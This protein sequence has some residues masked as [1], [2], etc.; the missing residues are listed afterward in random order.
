MAGSNGGTFT[1]QPDGTVTF[2]PGDDFN[3]LGVG[4]TATTEITYTIDDGQGGTD[5]ATIVQTVTGV[6]DAPI[7]VDP[8]QPPID[9][10]NPPD[11]VPFDPQ[12]PF[13]PPL[14]PENYIPVQSGDD[15][16]PQP[17]LDLTPYFGDPD[18]PDPV[19]LSIDPNDLPP[20]LVFDPVTG[21]ISGTP[22]LDASQGGDPQNPGTYVIPVTAIDPS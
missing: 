3:G 7:P 10:N 13:N 18:S 20:G 17:P 8:T 14:D 9:P 22:T 19:T 21:V 4:E 12:T 1:V 16:A 6:N 5:T 11:G 15:S 2:D